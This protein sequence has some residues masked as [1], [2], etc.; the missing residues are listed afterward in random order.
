MK[1]QKIKIANILGIEELEFEP[2]QFTVIEGKNGTGKTTILESIKHVLNGGH[3]AKLL[4]NGTDKG[5]IVLIL[6]DGIQLT[7]TVTQNKS[8]VQVLD[9]EGNIINK[10]QTY[11]DKLIDMLSVNPIK[12]LTA[13]K[14][15]RVNYL[16]EAIPMK[17]TKE[18]LE[19]LG[20]MSEKIHDDLSGHA[21]D[22]LD[23]IYK[24]FYDE[25]TGVNR[26]LKEKT[27]TM[28][29]LKESIT[30]VNYSLDELLEKLKLTEDKKN[31]I[32]R[33]RSIFLDQ[34]MNTRTAELDKERERFENEMNRLRYEHENKKQEINNWFENKKTEIESKFNEK[35]L[36]TISELSALKEQQKQYNIQEKT[37]ELVKQFQ[38]ECSKLKEESE[39]LSKALSDL[40]KLKNNILK[41][42]P[43]DGLEIRDGDVY[44][45]G[46]QFDKLNTAEQVKIAVDV[47]TLR[48]GSLGI[49]CVDGIEKLDNNTFK[50][51]KLKAIE[52]G[53]QM[54]VTK[55]SDAELNIQADKRDR[56]KLKFWKQIFANK[57]TIK[58]REL[59]DILLK[60]NALEANPTNNTKILNL[61]FKDSQNGYIKQ[62][63][64]NS[65]VWELIP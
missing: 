20:D 29:Q 10:P 12:F 60:L 33:K 28:T 48:A 52:S 38:N 58:E 27:A 37:R 1:I 4:R 3:D 57:A 34:L 5:E 39:K 9:K 32:E 19:I 17:L 59:V 6:D 36:P 21:I 51:F 53:L 13:E 63:D 18:H 45:K 15:D 8:V 16:L 22:A 14:K 26:A 46:I 49:I 40:E 31:E 56:E 55:V 62:T 30:E 35:Y 2:T 65:H 64:V 41:D 23:R 11:I 43:I 24:Q 54:I 47:A 42:L 44:C 7:K 61:I 50:E 25:R